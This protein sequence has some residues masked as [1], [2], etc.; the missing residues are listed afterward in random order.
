MRNV[1]RVY[2]DSNEMGRAEVYRKQTL[3][4]ARDLQKQY[5]GNEDAKIMLAICLFD[6]ATVSV[7]SQSLLTSGNAR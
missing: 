3:G 2:V 4:I 1:G 5:P 6:L 7:N